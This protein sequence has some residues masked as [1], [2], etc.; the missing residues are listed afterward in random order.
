MKNTTSLLRFQQEKNI[1]LIVGM[2]FLVLF[3]V[4]GYDG[5]TFSDDVYYLLAGKSFWEGTMEVNS[6]HFSSRWGAYVPSGL[7]GHIFGFNPHIISGFSLIC[8]LVTLLILAKI[9]PDKKLTWILV[10]WFCCQVY[11]LHFITKVYPDAPLVLWV[12]MIPAVAIFRNQKPFLSGVVLVIALFVGF[13]T[14]ETI[15]FLAPFVVILFLFDLRNKSINNVFYLSFLASALLLS[16]L[17]LAYFWIQF[18]DPLYRITSINS[19]HYISEFTYADKGIWSIVE[20]LTIT[21]IITFVERAYWPWLVFAIPGI[22]QGLK[23][24]KSPAFEFT[25]SFLCLFVGFWFMSSTLEFYNPIYLNPR[26]LIILVPI[27][28]FL[29][30]IGWNTWQ[31]SKK[32]KQLLYGMIVIGAIVATVNS[33]VKQALFLT[34]FIL[35]IWIKNRKYQLLFLGFVLIIPALYSIYYQKNLKRYS[36]LTDKLIQIT[37][38]ADKQTPILVNNFIDFSKGVMLPSAKDAQ[39]T[40][41]PIENFYEISRRSPKEIK[42]LIYQYYQHAY[43]KE[44]E[45]VTA[46][47]DWLE[48]SNYELIEE[49]IEG[50]L[51]YRKYRLK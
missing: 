9:V 23:Q 11:F 49:S 7:V 10:I 44:A 2:L 18:G 35:M 27:L 12:T 16:I 14:K 36:D 39:E 34:L 29:I 50:Q 38:S 8:Y 20:R 33:D 22:Y 32:W 3:W 51:W 24:N 19:G 4:F 15:I 48:S 13:L 1:A 45:D 41:F 43:P 28:A 47:N 46:L 30:A 26:H 25:V 37:Y 17:Y 5:I 6:Y 21:P 40:L 31:N 42:V